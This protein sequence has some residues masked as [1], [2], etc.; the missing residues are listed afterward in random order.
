[1]LGPWASLRARYDG[2]VGLRCVSG[3]TP[4]SPCRSYFGVSF[5]SLLTGG[6]LGDIVDVPPSVST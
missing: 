2:D 5:N 6:V 4:N 1:M 3:M